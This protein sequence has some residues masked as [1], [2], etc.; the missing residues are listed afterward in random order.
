[1]VDNAVNLDVLEEA[2]KKEFENGNYIL[3]NDKIFWAA[4]YAIPT[5]HNPTGMTMSAGK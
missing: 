1:M 3:G 4:Y 5:F 2:A